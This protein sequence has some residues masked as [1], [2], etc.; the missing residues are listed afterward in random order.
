[1]NDLE[2][3]AKPKAG[4]MKRIFQAVGIIALLFV[5]LVVLVVIFGSRSE[6]LPIATGNIS[7]FQ[8]RAKI[9]SFEDLAR[10]TESYENNL[11]YYTG[12]VI[13]VMEQGSNNYA[14][15]INVTQD[16]RLD[17]WSDPILVL[18]NCPVRPLEDDVVEFV[19]KVSGRQSYKTVLGAT[20]TLPQVTAQAF[21]VTQ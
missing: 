13:Q 11:V 12:Q 18:C 10:S 3:K 16:T 20:V 1:M 2:T 21:R 8:A 7:A 9:V 15:R 4:C 19:G 14:M 5:G 6:P 17:M